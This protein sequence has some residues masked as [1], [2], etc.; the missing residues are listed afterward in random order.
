M[1]SQLIENIIDSFEKDML[2]QLEGIV[3]KKHVKNI[4]NRKN[5]PPEYADMVEVYENS[6]KRINGEFVSPEKAKDLMDTFYHNKKSIL[7]NFNIWEKDINTMEDLL[8]VSI[9]VEGPMLDT[10]LNAG[11]GK[12]TD[13]KEDAEWKT[14][15]LLDYDFAKF[16]ERASDADFGLERWGKQ[17]FDNMLKDSSVDFF[18]VSNNKDIRDSWLVIQHGNKSKLIDKKGN[19]QPLTRTILMNNGWEF[20]GKN[21]V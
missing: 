14:Y 17:Q 21:N 12:Y 10:V 5:F 18:A 9:L 7:K 20:M 16:V 3:S 11:K 19:V 1:E 15:N 2:M 8:Y 6:N 4:L 13:G